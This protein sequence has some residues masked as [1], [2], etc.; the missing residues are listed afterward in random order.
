MNFKT[1]KGTQTDILHSSNWFGKSL[2]QREKNA[3][4]KEL[5]KKLSHDDEL[6]LRGY[7]TALADKNH[8]YHYN[9]NKKR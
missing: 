1:K 9:K 8:A 7:A 5:H 6:L 3:F 2:L 4:S